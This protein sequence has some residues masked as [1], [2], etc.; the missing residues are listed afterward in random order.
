MPNVICETNMKREFNFWKNALQEG[1]KEG[2]S[3]CH[4]RGEFKFKCRRRVRHSGIFTRACARGQNNVG[5]RGQ[6]FSFGGEF[7]KLHMSV[8]A[9]PYNDIPQFMRVRTIFHF[10]PLF[11]KQNYLL[12]KAYFLLKGR[13]IPSSPRC[14]Q[15]EIHATSFRGKLESALVHALNN[16]KREH[17]SRLS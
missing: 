4:L 1:R 17:Q 11:R 7:R 2:R 15:Q 12:N 13:V 10:G 16:V 6:A 5:P 14:R 8:D 3:E 9:S